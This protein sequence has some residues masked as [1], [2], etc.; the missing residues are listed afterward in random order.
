MK[1]Y[2]LLV[3]MLLSGLANAGIVDFETKPAFSCAGENQ[4][5][6][7]ISF[8][9]FGCYYSN[10]E[11]ADY[12]FVPNSTVIGLA[13]FQGFGYVS[14]GLQGG[15]SFTL[16]KMDISLAVYANPGDLLTVTGLLNGAN[17]QAVVLAPSQSAF[18]NYSFNWNDIDEVR[19][20]W[21]QGGWAGYIGFDNIQYNMQQETVS[22]PSSLV[23]LGL[24]LI[25]FG[26]SR[27][28]KNR[29]K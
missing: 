19:F 16:N 11:P 10:S 22:A 27:K 14:F 20:S 15:G 7:G 29:R 26:Y 9:G 8:N 18:T 4:V 21:G 25:G 3:G 23:L 12:P 1:K 6:N 28:F 2:L 17:M 24:S 13:D 5:D